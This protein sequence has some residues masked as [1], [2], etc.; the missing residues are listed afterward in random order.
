[1]NLEI[2]KAA[3][4]PAAF[5]VEPRGGRHEMQAARESNARVVVELDVALERCLAGE[6]RLHD[7]GRKAFETRVEIER[8]TPPRALPRNDHLAV[9]PHVRACVEVELRREIVERARAIEGELDR[10]QARKVGE[11]GENA[12]GRLGGVHVE[13]ETVSGGNVGELSFEIARRVESLRGQR[14]IEA[15]GRRSKR[16]LAGNAEARRDAHHRLS[17]R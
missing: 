13:R 6:D 3:R 5:K 4:G 1:M 2:E 14:E 7:P 8:Q 16:R 9:R 15:F 17:K 10:R 11:M 12:A